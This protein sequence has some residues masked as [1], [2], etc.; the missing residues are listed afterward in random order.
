MKK[1]YTLLLVIVSSYFFIGKVNAQCVVNAVPLADT[2]D[3]GDTAK[4]F[5]SGFA[6]YALNN[7]F[8]LGNAGPGWQATSS[9]QFDNPY[10]PS[11]TNDTYLWMG[12]QADVPR[13]LTSIGLDLTYGGQICFDL[14]Y[15]VQS[16]PTPTEGPDEP[17]EGV[18]LQYSID[19]GTTWIDIAY[20]I[21]NGTS[22]DPSGNGWGPGIW[23]SN[24]GNASTAPGASGQ[25]PF[26]QWA[27]Y[28][29]P[30]PVGAQT[31]S[32]Q[33]QWSQIFSSTENFDHWGLDN[34]QVFLADPTYGFFDENWN[35]LFDNPIEFVPTGTNT[36][37]YYYT[38]LIDDTCSTTA[39]VYMNPTDAGP[40]FLVSCGGI[41]R[42]IN[43]TGVAP[44]AT[45]SWSPTAGLSDPSVPN[46]YVNPTQD[47]EYF[48]TSD[49]GV[50]S[51]MVFVEDSFNIHFNQ[52]DTI[53]A[54][55]SEEIML[56][57]TPSS[58]SIAS[59]EWN[60][61]GTLNDSTGNNVTASPM[62]TTQYVATVTSDSGCVIQDSVL[63]QVQGV[64]L[65]IAVTPQNPTVCEGS[66]VDL[67]VGISPDAPAYILVESSYN[68]MSTTGGTTIT[69][70][71]DETTVGPIS[72]GFNFPFFGTGY[73]EVYLSSNG[74]ISFNSL[75]SAYIGNT[76]IPST[77]LP[78]NIIAWLWDD[79]NFSS[80]GTASYYTGGTAPNRYV[81]FN[82]IGVNHFGS[83]NTVSV[84]VILYEN[85]TV[86]INNI[87][88]QNDGTFATM[89]QGIEN[90]TGT[91]GYAID[92]LNS[93]SFTISQTSFSYIPLSPPV[94]PNYTWTP[95]TWLSSTSGATVTSTPEG[96]IEYTVNMQDGFCTTSA[97]VYVNVDT[98][99]IDSLSDDIAL[100]CPDDNIQLYGAA[101][102][103]TLLQP[104][105]SVI[106]IGTDSVLSTTTYTPYR[107]LWEDARL[108]YLFYASELSAQ[109]LVAGDNL[110]GIAFQVATSNSTM[111][112][113]GF[114]ISMAHSNL[115]AM[116]G[117][118]TTG[119]VTVA[120][121]STYNEHLG[122]NWHNFSTNFTWDGV[123]NIIVQACFDNNDWTNNDAVY[124]TE[125][126]Q[127]TAVYDVTD[128]ASGCSL[129]A[130]FASN[131][132]PN[133]RFK[134]DYVPAGYA[135][136]SYQWS[137]NPAWT[138]NDDTIQ[139]PII[140]DEVNTVTT[141]YLEVSDGSC[142]TID[143]LE[144][145]FAGSLTVSND[146]TICEGDTVQLFANGG[147]NPVW[148]PNN[149]SLSNDTIF[150]PTAYPS[151]TTTYNVDVE[152][153]NC[154]VNGQVTVTVNEIDA[155]ILNGGASQVGTCLDEPV[156]LLTN[157][158]SSY[159]MVW[160][161]PETG[162]GSSI[163][164]NTTGLYTLTI[165]DALGCSR[166]TDI[167]VNI[168]N[169]ATLNTDL[170]RNVLCCNDTV[171]IDFDAIVEN[172]VALDRVYWNG[173]INPAPGPVTLTSGVNA[174]YGIRTVDVNGCESLTEY[175][176]TTACN[177]GQIEAL[178][179][180]VIN[181]THEY[182]VV[183]SL[184]NTDY[185]WYPASRFNG[186]TF[187]ADSAG[188][189]S[190]SVDII[191][192]FV[193]NN[194]DNFSCIETDSTTVYVI[195]VSN[196]E[197]PNAFSPNG[198]GKNDLFFPVYL[199]NNS[200]V[201]TFNV[202]NRW[203]ELVY[204]YNNDNGWDGTFQGEDQPVDVYNYYIVID[205]ITENYIISGSVSLFR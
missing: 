200:N 113:S 97:T 58:V 20:F 119:F 49:C 190:V 18:S 148:T 107:G 124:Y 64:G 154:T 118:V 31:N 196:P 165:T 189:N 86:V 185:V 151:T 161:G 59:V 15:A 104:K 92:S 135:P 112:Y 111:P 138:F 38:N 123:S 172:G 174:T 140:T 201:T 43:A 68:L 186:N 162:T 33:I 153:T 37:T 51:M 2:L 53:C 180:L 89:T 57:T 136:I 79:L 40:D 95:P 163:V 13:N 90:G 35:F 98:I 29:F 61:V 197:M 203:G 26:T 133:V 6:D 171:V 76:I 47:T 85:G 67:T 71:G 179:T 141:V 24:P 134:T 10:I 109:G 19:G 60:N 54:N 63:L 81:V 5:L 158:A 69:G 156:T 199:D 23:V 99:T 77:N 36:T 155:P 132:R 103:T 93:T 72:L 150:N 173:N 17:D 137:S 191:N 21:P 22:V 74:F 144:I 167:Q 157:A 50:D 192:Q 177:N 116:T 139:N 108:Q 106:Q 122:W 205:K 145:N 11:L 195:E 7:D 44:W 130:P 80:G 159:D 182:Q 101:S 114:T 94:N 14:V 178:D 8:N 147:S 176:V 73:N 188:L 100:S 39:T 125:T 131:D 83:S 110:S 42:Q 169:P 28:C 56:T 193:L 62:I 70:L 117:F 65:P 128:G 121:S 168:A 9:A 170:V 16:D 12:D 102:T 82:F 30:I 1:I 78:N 198:D 91:E 41:G 4:I 204:Q 187:S 48:I 146:T 142:T 175:T 164:V 181:Q 96:D 129:N 46:P 202:Y 32:T 34:V 184:D 105:D 75:A 160:T 25:T 45:V 166:S 27:T 55:G 120:P 126:V 152:L 66:S 149:S 84:Q 127:N 115:T 52:L 194:G 3:C 88:V 143:S 87:D 183:N